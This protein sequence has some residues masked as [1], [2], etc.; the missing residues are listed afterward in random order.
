VS[1]EEL[2]RHEWIAE[3]SGMAIAHG[4]PEAQADAWALRMWAEYEAARKQHQ[5][6]AGAAQ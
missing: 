5:I 2:H 3:R 6:D 1:D 4:S